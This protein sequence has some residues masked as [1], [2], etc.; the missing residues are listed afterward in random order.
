VAA[1]LALQHGHHYKLREL[2]ELVG[3][4]AGCCGKSI[5]PH[6]PVV[7][8]KIFQCET[9][10]HLQGLEID[11]ATYEAYPPEVVGSERKLVYGGKIGRRQWNRLAANLKTNRPAAPHLNL[12]AA[13]RRFAFPT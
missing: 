13:R 1:H 5:D 9:G 8:E 7:G 11:T 12:S 6:H 3:L 2:K 4:V 10:L